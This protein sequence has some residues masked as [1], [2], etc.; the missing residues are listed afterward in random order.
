MRNL[1]AI[2]CGKVAE[3]PSLRSTPSGS[4]SLVLNI[5]TD[6]G[7]DGANILVILTG[8]NV[9]DVAQD[10]RLGTYIRAEGPALFECRQGVGGARA[11]LSVM[12]DSIDVVEADSA[13]TELTIATQ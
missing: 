7:A 4:S 10:V 5:G 9:E 13:S 1:H 6:A 8:E 12:A 2:I 3:A 11:L